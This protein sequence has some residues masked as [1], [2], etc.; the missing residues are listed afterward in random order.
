MSE[1]KLEMEPH[2]TNFPNPYFL[3][4]SLRGDGG[5]ALLR[6]CQSGVILTSSGFFVFLAI[7]TQ[8][9]LFSGSFRR[10]PQPST[11][12]STSTHRTH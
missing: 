10:R 7:L 6:S 4:W 9:E 12:H 2:A 1:G 5:G 3:S 8:S 11:T